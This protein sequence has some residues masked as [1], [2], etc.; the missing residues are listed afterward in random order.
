[1]IW[2]SWSSGKDS[3][4]A[5]YELRKD[6]RVNVVA[7]L[8]TINETHERVAM[9]AVRDKLLGRQAE[10]MGL[11][12]HRI[13]IPAGCTNEIYEARMKEAIAIAAHEG[14]THMAFGDLFLEDIK[15]YRET[16]LKP[17]G[18]AAIFPLWKRPTA[19]L[20][21][22]MIA[23]G[24]K[25]IIT[26]VDPKKLPASFA[27]REF[28]ESF[29]ND[30]PATVDPCGENGEFHSFVYDSPLFKKPIPVQVG[31]VVERDGFIFADVF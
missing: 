6:P 13:K 10:E 14:V 4:F 24:Q 17:T 22:E 2:M 31:E 1:M 27:G 9:H 23:I 21:R 16:M 11:K 15:N 28:D 3:A 8:T 25:A 30:L 5:L 26:C 12:L 20:A 19:K 29:L 7:L 18:M